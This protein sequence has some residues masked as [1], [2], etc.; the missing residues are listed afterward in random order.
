MCIRIRLNSTFFKRALC[1][2]SSLPFVERLPYT[3]LM[4]LDISIPLSDLFYFQRRSLCSPKK[5]F[6]AHYVLSMSLFSMELFL[7]ENL[8]NGA[9]ENGTTVKGNDNECLTRHCRNT[10]EFQCYGNT[11]HNVSYVISN[12]LYRCIYV[13]TNLQSN[14]K[15]L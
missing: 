8:V 13:H 12:T 3:F 15:Y 6:C 2:I 10:F 7:S 5:V 4:S 1:R 9:L 11:N 14:M